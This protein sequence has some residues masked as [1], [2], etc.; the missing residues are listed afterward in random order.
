MSTLSVEFAPA[1]EAIGPGEWRSVAGTRNPF[2]RYEFLAALEASGCVGARTGWQPHHVRVRRGAETLALAPCYIKTHSFGE[3][4]FDWSWADAYQRHGLDYYPKLLLAVPFTPSQG[5]RVMTTGDRDTDIQGETIVSAL[6]EQCQRLGASSWH[7]LFP[8]LPSLQQVESS[9]LMPRLGCQF[10]W[11]NRGYEGF[12]AFL[13]ELA[14]RKRKNI[15]KE[16]AAV[17]EQGIDFDWMTGATIDDRALDRFF[18]FYQATYLKRGH[19]PYLNRDF[20]FRL[21][22]TM[23]EQLLLIM[24]RKA[25]EPVAGALFLRND[26]SLFGRY[27]GCLEEYDFLHF[28]TCYYQG[29]DYCIAEGLGEFDA[30]AQGEHKLQRGFEPVITESRHWIAHPAFRAAIAEF[31]QEEAADVRHYAAVAREHLPFRRGAG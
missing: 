23:P 6:I 16:R 31:V 7:L 21:R 2:V 4:V 1:I 12:D 24:A 13:G 25:G 14:S 22:E 10:R 17:R 9:A 18:I 27:W 20:F 15:R 28:E 29:I 19:R 11:F 30:G 3:Y 5:P 26:Q 8:D